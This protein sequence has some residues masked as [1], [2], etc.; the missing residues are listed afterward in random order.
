MT[1]FGFLLLLF[2]GVPAL[3]APPP[4]PMP[5][6]DA[7][8]RNVDTIHIPPRSPVRFTEWLK[9]K[10]PIAQFEG[11]FVLSGTYYYGNSQKNAGP[12][13]AGEAFIVPDG[14]EQLPQ[15]VQRAGR[16]TIG[17]DNPEVFAFEV[18]PPSVLQRVR[19]KGGGYA[20]GHVAVRVEGFTIAIAC[21]SP[22]YGTHFASVY[23]PSG[24]RVENTRPP[25]GGC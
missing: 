14:N 3:A 17:I 13:F 19:R 22:S 2:L 23:R 9:G 24:A 21:D 1:R 12:E 6:N 5:F 20:S 25:V 16:R 8:G 11:R 10:S 15:F 7:Q 4:K 18:I